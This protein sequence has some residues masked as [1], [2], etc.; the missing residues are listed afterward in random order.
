MQSTAAVSSQATPVQQP[1]TG[2]EPPGDLTRP[3]Q[4]LT[5]FSRALH[6]RDRALMG[7]TWDHSPEAA[8]ENPLGGIKRGWPEI[9]SV[10]ERLFGVQGPFRFE[11]SDATR[12]E[13]DDV[14]YAV[15]RER[16]RLQT[17]HGP[18]ALA[19]RTTR[20]FRRAADDRWRQ[21]HHHGS[22][23]SPGLLHDYQ[24]AVSDASGAQG[25]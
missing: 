15:G 16:G 2:A 17:E 13:F 24:Q 20:I 5:Q 23:D 3:K 12:H 10:Y 18:L 6:G 25:R 4:A 11:F 9:R 7:D 14:L 1:M 21:I 19:I 8:M 22:I